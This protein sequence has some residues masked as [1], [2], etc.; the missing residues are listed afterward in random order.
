MYKQ[1]LEAAK[2]AGTISEADYAKKL[3][4][5]NKAEKQHKETQVSLNETTVKFNKSMRAEKI[6][7]GF[8]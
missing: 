1:K 4:V 6:A 7:K 2:K 8:F 3:A 5:L